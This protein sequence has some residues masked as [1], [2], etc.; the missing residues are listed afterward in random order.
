ME[1]GVDSGIEGIGRG[2][3]AGGMNPGGGGILKSLFE[4]VRWDDLAGKSE[5][6]YSNNMLNKIALFRFEKFPFSVIFFNG[7][8]LLLKEI[9]YK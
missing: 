7:K 9:K 1:E 6:M 4:S 5:K 8:F 2:G 3:I